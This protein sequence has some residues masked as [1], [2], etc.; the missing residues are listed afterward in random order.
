ML[1]PRYQKALRK[2]FQT[3]SKPKDKRKLLQYEPIIAIDKL[4]MNKLGAKA[5]LQ[6]QIIELTTHYNFTDLPILINPAIGRKLGLLGQADGLK[7][8]AETSK[9]MIDF[10]NEG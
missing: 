6:Q 8:L 10:F 4:Y 3:A 1:C 5:N 7:I 9:L 2:T